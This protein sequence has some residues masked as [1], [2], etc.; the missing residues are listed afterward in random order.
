[1]AYPSPQYT[2]TQVNKSGIYL[3]NLQ[4]KKY[5]VDD[6]IHTY[7]V[8]SNGRSC[9]GYPINTF[10]ATLRS[11]LNRIDDGGIVAQRLKLA[12]SIVAKLRR[13]P[14]MKLSTMQNIGGLPGMVSPAFV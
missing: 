12:P 10:Q 11:R 3:A 8:L 4:G 2:R 13:F 14:H 9:H 7:D 5:D 6:L 1:M